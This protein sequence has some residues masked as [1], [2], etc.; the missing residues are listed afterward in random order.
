MADGP[1]TVKA[2]FDTGTEQLGEVDVQG[3]AAYS[4]D[5]LWEITSTDFGKIQH[6]E[7]KRRNLYEENSDRLNL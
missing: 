3:H 6:S 1:G 5:R 7:R 2:L 4:G